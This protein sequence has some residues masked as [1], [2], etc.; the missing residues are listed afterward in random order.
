MG[1]YVS[2]G[3]SLRKSQRRMS[4]REKHE[5]VQLLWFAIVATFVIHLAMLLD[6]NKSFF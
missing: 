1:E 5:W 3:Q 2:T 6:A 4:E